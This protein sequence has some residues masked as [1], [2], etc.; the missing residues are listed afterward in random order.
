MACSWSPGASE[1]P[2]K[3]SKPGP[4]QAHLLAEADLHL[5]GPARALS[6]PIVNG[7]EPSPS[8]A[9][10]IRCLCMVHPPPVLVG[11][12]VRAP[13]E[14]GCAIVDQLHL[15]IAATDRHVEVECLL[16]VPGADVAVVVTPT[17]LLGGR[18]G[19]GP[20]ACARDPSM[21]DDV[22]ARQQEGRHFVGQ[23]S[24]GLDV[25][26]DGGADDSGRNP[27]DK[28][29]AALGLATVAVGPAAVV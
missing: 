5:E 28:C 27:S 29:G 11:V 14:A 3:R 4:S 20:G 15:A 10:S 7:D 19:C 21:H 16:E 25:L 9:R 26:D 13:G 24:T 12:R 2:G 8:L 17:P 6:S 1:V 18:H 22:K 23:R